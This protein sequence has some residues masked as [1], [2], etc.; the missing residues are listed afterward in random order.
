[1]LLSDIKYQDA[2]V[3]LLRCAGASDRVAHAYLFE[4][5]PGV[6]KRLAACAWA[7][8]LLCEKPKNG[9]QGIDAC[10][11]C[12]SCHLMDRGTHPDF[13]LFQREP[14]DAQFRIHLITP[15]EGKSPDITVNQS[16]QMSP[17]MSERIVTVLDEAD[18][19]NEDAANAFLKTLEE[20]PGFAVLILVACDA[21]RLPATIASRC[22][23]VRFRPL[24]QKFV[25]EMVRRQSDVTEEEARYVS[26]CAAGSIQEALEL[27]STGL[28]EAKRR[29]ISQL[30]QTAPGEVFD[31]AGEIIS[32]VDKTSKA[33]T[34]TKSSVE[35]NSLRRKFH[36]LILAQI[37]LFYRDALVLKAGADDVPLVH[38]DQRELLQ[39]LAGAM[40]ECVIARA[41]EII[42]RSQRFLA[43]NAHIALTV[44][45]ALLGL[46]R[47]AWRRSP[48]SAR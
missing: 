8:L 14:S 25:A 42:E 24:P 44:E 1:M 5:P 39:R 28:F 38:E 19:M 45:N 27:A 2:A 18:T 13:H 36:A 21:S 48:A 12:K 37:M 16:V 41:I 43:R 31:L 26:R 15:R 9:G 23:L 10:G 17:M 29:W 22:Q 46:S 6:G 35:M 34:E 7:K 3:S 30:M 4:G 40:D 32:W 20:A 33:R 47:L 11:R